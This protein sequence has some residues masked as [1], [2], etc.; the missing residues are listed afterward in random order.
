VTYARADFWDRFYQQRRESGDDLDWA[1]LWTEPFLV[2][3]QQAGV[4]TI[5]ELGC[6][7]GNDAARLA[8]AGYSV[9]A[10]DLSGEAV[11]Q[12]RAKFGQ[13]V[14]FVVADIAQRLPFADGSFDAVMSNVAMHMFP[15]DVTRAVFAEVGRV[16]HVGGLFVFHVNALEDRPLRARWQPARELE[17]DFV[18]EEWGQTVHFFSEVYLRELLGGWREL[19]LRQLQIPHRKTGEPFKHVWRGIAHR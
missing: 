10:A 12:A 19:D 5:L 16:V 18:V 15:D 9:T 17:P 3:L 13:A 7:T 14:R 8:D 11:E 4:R 6:G 2:P 1:G